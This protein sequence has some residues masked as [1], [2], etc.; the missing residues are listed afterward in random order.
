MRPARSLC[1]LLLALPGCLLGVDQSV[2]DPTLVG[3][4]VVVS[5][6]PGPDGV[7]RARAGTEVVVVV[8]T[9]NRLDLAASELTLGGRAL[10]CVEEGPDVPT[11]R[12]SATLDG[13]EAEGGV[14]LRGELSDGRRSVTDASLELM[15]FDFTPPVASCILAPRVAAATSEVT[16]EVVT[17]EALQGGAPTVSSTTPGVVVETLEVGETSFRYGITG[18]VGVDVEAYV[19]TVEGADLAGNPAQGDGLCDPASLT[20]TWYG[21][22][23]VLDGEPLVTATDGMEID[24]L[25]TATVGSVVSVTLPLVGEVDRARSVVS[26]SGLVLAPTPDAPTTWSTTLAAGV[27]DGPKDLDA[28]LFDVAGNPLQVQRSRV[29]RF[30]TTPPQV[31]TAVLRRSPAFAPA[32]ADLDL[33]AFSAHDPVTGGPVSGVLEVTST[34]VL[35][36][37]PTLIAQGGEALTFRRELRGERTVAWHVDAIPAGL[38]T[39]VAFSVV[40]ADRLGNES[41]ALPLG[42]GMRVDGDAPAPPDTQTA[43]RITVHRVPWGAIAT[44]GAPAFWVEGSAGAVPADHFVQARVEGQVLGIVQAEADG[45]FAPIELPADVVDVGVTTVD[46]AGNVSPRAPVR[47]GVWVA[48]LGGRVAGRPASNPHVLRAATAASQG[49]PAMDEVARAV[50]AATV[51]PRIEHAGQARW[52]EVGPSADVP[53]ARATLGLVADV[54]RQELVL[55]G[56]QGGAGGF[57]TT[58]DTF[59]WDGARWF[60][61]AQGLS[62][63]APMSPSSMAWDGQRQQVILFSGRLDT[64]ALWAWEGRQWV[65]VGVQGD[66]PSA[67]QGAAM[68]WDPVRR[69]VVMFGGADASGMLDETWTWDGVAWEAHATV[70]APSPRGSAT[71]A[72]DGR[73]ERVI[74]FGGLIAGTPFGDTWA[75]DGEAWSPVEVATAPSARRLPGMVWDE[76]REELLLFGGWGPSDQRLAD[77]WVLEEGTWTRRTP[78]TSPPSRLEVALAYDPV[79]RQPV[80]FGGRQG[81][82]TWLGDMWAW[83]GSTWEPVEPSAGDLGTRWPTAGAWDAAREEAVLFGGH[84]SNATTW[85]FDGATWSDHPA[86]GALGT[87]WP[88]PRFSHAMAYDPVRKVVVLHGGKAV[89]GEP[90]TQRYGGTW[91]WDGTTWTRRTAEDVGPGRRS[92]HVMTWDPVRQGVLLFGGKDTSQRTLADTWLWTGTSWTNVTPSGTNPPA[93]EEPVFGT[94]LARQQVVLASG[95]VNGL[96]SGET[97]SDTWVWNGS[98]WTALTTAPFPVRR[99]RWGTYWD[100]ANEEVVGFCAVGVVDGVARSFVAFDGTAWRVVDDI[101]TDGPTPRQGAMAVWDEARQAV[102]V[103]G[104]YD[105]SLVED[106]WVLDSDPDGRPE[107]RLDVDWSSARVPG[108]DIRRIDVAWSAGGDGLQGSVPEGGVRLRAWLDGRWRDVA[109]HDAPA[110]APQPLCWTLV[111]DGPLPGSACAELALER[112]P[113]RMLVGT[114]AIRLHLSAVPVGTNG[115]RGDGQP[116]YARLVTDTVEVTVRYRLTVE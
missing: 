31:A 28:R 47:D 85:T 98:A 76:D 104:G 46:E 79:R 63:P 80:F 36:A 12:C 65:R 95:F 89:E 100:T 60:E 11:Y 105:G 70:D 90:T 34:E 62:G 14:R 74:L 38:S 81:G 113:E 56:G 5:P 57:A 93:R 108:S 73:T 88:E 27:G 51:G 40:L 42:V 50:D 37:D 96:P 54:A 32:S 25:L 9:R 115:S 39:E 19:L 18:P 55:F 45:S 2:P 72:W 82:G 44:G 22:G 48:G 92:N 53:T 75:W 10:A 23:L 33:V 1:C 61:V 84:G 94:D 102:V 35:G 69:R 24:D 91:T 101:P 16:L 86:S 13:S 106:A 52:R 99:W 66:R 109:A 26:L 41:T 116:P 7:V 78:A 114:D 67:R 64:D 8:Q 59:T 77:T 17:S 30:D 21:V 6:A 58:D 97:T 71:M 43:G 29:V 103:A 110:D 3:D 107:Q 15:V 87:S 83:D 20:G 68:A 112:G 4:P 49:L 111:R